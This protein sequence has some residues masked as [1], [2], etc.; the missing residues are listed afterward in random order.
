[1]QTRESR[2]AVRIWPEWTQAPACGAGYY[3]FSQIPA[4][5]TSEDL[6]REEIDRQ[7]AA[8]GRFVQDH[9]SFGLSHMASAKRSVRLR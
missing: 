3:F 9:K 8:C 4:A 1:M 5:M 7:L 2:V 6:A